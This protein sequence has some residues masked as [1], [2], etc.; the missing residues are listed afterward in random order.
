MGILTCITSVRDGNTLT[1]TFLGNQ[2]VERDDF[3][4]EAYR[5][6]YNFY[7]GHQQLFLLLREAIKNLYDHGT[8]RGV[9]TLIKCHQYYGFE[10]IDHNPQLVNFEAGRDGGTWV[11]KSKSNFGV[12]MNM[13][14]GY[15]DRDCSQLCIDDTKGGINYSGYYYEQNWEKIEAETFIP[16]GV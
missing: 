10:L 16:Q 12:G 6:I 7:K 15:K 11:K 1:I 2:N 4:G 3:K 8:G 9:L 5:E 13:I 14:Y